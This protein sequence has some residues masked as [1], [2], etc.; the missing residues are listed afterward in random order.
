MYDYYFDRSVTKE[1][2]YVYS[3]MD[4]N[5]EIFYIGKG[6]GD[7][8][9]RHFYPSS[10]KSSNRKNN[11]IKNIISSGGKVIVDVL[12]NGIEKEEDALSLEEHLINSYGVKREGGI[13]YNELT[14]SPCGGDYSKS[15]SHWDTIRSRYTQEERYGWYNVH[16]TPEAREKRS[17]LSKVIWENRSE[18]EKEELSRPLYKAGN[19]PDYTYY[20]LAD[21]MYAIYEKYPERGYTYYQNI[22]KESNKSSLVTILKGFNEGWNPREDKDYSEFLVKH[23][24]YPSLVKQV[25]LHPFIEVYMTKTLV[26]Y[27]SSCV[28]QDELGKYFIGKEDISEAL[29]ISKSAYGKSLQSL[30]ETK[31][32]PFYKVLESIDNTILSIHHEDGKYSSLS[33]LLNSENT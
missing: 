4:E 5:R 32:T 22:F 1:G 10:L 2:F 9:F 11:K 28:Y 25:S 7:R 29:G 27:N 26:L 23:D 21:V 16:R 3:L 24:R 14:R 17:R 20:L 8:C 13:L 33:N 30:K 31:L 18:K 6:K 19:I 12:V 15:G